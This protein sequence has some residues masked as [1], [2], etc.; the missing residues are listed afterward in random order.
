MSGRHET[1]PIF[2]SSQ[3]ISARRIGGVFKGWKWKSNANR[4]SISEALRYPM[5]K[6]V[7][8]RADSSTQASAGLSTEALPLRLV[9]VC[10]YYKQAKVNC[11]TKLCK[12]KRKTKT[13]VA[14]HLG[15]TSPKGMVKLPRGFFLPCG[16]AETARPDPRR[17]MM[18]ILTRSRGFRRRGLATSSRAQKR[19]LYDRIASVKLP[20]DSPSS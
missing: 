1:R 4:G 19:S 16:M 20:H 7:S 10:W 3:T 9:F 8:L 14:A 6:V 12:C 5:L 18:R 11:T 13:T 17:I 15:S 2:P